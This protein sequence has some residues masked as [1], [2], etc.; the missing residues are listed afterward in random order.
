MAYKTRDVSLAHFR[1]RVKS[2]TDTG[3]PKAYLSRVLRSRVHVINRKRYEYSAYVTGSTQFALRFRSIPPDWRAEDGELWIM[4]DVQRSKTEEKRRRI[5]LDKDVARRLSKCRIESVATF[6][7]VSV[8]VSSFPRRAEKCVCV[9]FG[10]ES[11][12]WEKIWSD[13][14]SARSWNRTGM[15]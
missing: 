9:S 3:P 14:C 13:K 10:Q 11:L 2:E 5:R 12:G 8:G 15:T 4:N 1:E 6:R 7:S